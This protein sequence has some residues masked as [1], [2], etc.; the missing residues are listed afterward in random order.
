MILKNTKI[1]FFVHSSSKLLYIR[2]VGYLCVNLISPQQKQGANGEWATGYLEPWVTGFEQL[3][4]IQ[5]NISP[6]K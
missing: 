2:N 1:C 6:A 4:L 5:L 3:N